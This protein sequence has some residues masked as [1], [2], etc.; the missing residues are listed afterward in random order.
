M[1]HAS[2]K[3]QNRARSAALTLAT[4]ENKPDLERVEAMA[5]LGKEDVD[6]LSILL[7]SSSSIEIQ[8]AV[9][10]QLRKLIPL[11]RF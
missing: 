5:L 1:T 3:I 4:D 2:P 11:R 6:Q 10:D 7:K 8:T 9:I